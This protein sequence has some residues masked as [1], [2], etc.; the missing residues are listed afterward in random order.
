LVASHS[1]VNAI[2]LLRD[3]GCT[4]LRP[5]F[6]CVGAGLEPSLARVLRAH[7][8]C[9]D[10]LGRRRTGPPNGARQGSESSVQRIDLATALDHR[11]LPEAA[12]RHRV[13]ARQD[14]ARRGL[15][16]LDRDWVDGATRRTAARS[17][18]NARTSAH[19]SINRYFR[20]GSGACRR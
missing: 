2:R 18:R 3:A 7:V 9:N 14:D 6:S 15:G 12:R 5:E 4:R 16:E 17:D 11:S 1:K 10:S 19:V 20:A 8:S 13:R